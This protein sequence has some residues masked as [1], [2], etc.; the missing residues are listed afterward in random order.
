M[1]LMTG[2]LFISLGIIALNVF[3]KVL[4][5]QL[6]KMFI[7]RKDDPDFITSTLPL[8]N[9]YYMFNVTNP[10]E[11]LNGA[12]LRVNEVGPFIFSE[13][14]DKRD[15]EWNDTE[16]S[17]KYDEYAVF[18]EEDN[19]NQTFSLDEMVTTFNPVVLTLAAMIADPKFPEYLYIPFQIL[20]LRFDLRVFITRP[21]RELL[22]GGFESD[23]IKEMYKIT[24][25]ESF[26]Q[27]KA[28]FLFAAN[29]SKTYRF[30]EYTGADD[31]EK[32]HKIIEI[33]DQTKT[34]LWNDERCDRIEGF[35]GPPFPKPITKNTTLYM[36]SEGM[37][38][39]ITFD[40]DKEV[41]LKK[42]EMFR[43]KV[44][45]SLLEAS[46]E[47]EC[48]CN[49]EFLCRNQFADFSSI[50]EGIPL[51]ASYPHFYLADQKDIDEI[52]GLN[53]QEDIHETYMDIEP[54]TGL[55]LRIRKRVQVNMVVRR[56]AKLP[57]FSK[58][59]EGI[60]PIFW[61]NTKLDAPG[62]KLDK[63]YYAVII[64]SKVMIGSGA[65]FIVIGVISIAVVAA[66]V[67]GEKQ[68]SM[69][70][71]FTNEIHSILYQST[72]PSIIERNNNDKYEFKKLAK[73]PP[74]EKHVIL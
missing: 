6:N 38:R 46:K 25:M 41:R 17:V 31:I 37:R 20:I 74:S 4:Q 40:Y 3:P 53:P 61:M 33:D 11:F 52:S 28:G 71:K 50:S 72:N 34:D 23:L 63:L 66:L 49:D 67:I 57:I 55:L 15:V 58:V 24:K 21:V 13:W 45:D 68:S 32:L 47:N 51:V 1:L 19:R 69:I 10:S 30:K 26:S 8:Y 35:T 2:L 5:K 62:D 64:S 73:S 36:Y 70:R 12:Q 43:F 39:S 42:L 18:H 7:P 9:E 16:H 22:F 56:Y 44:P 29:N 48:F 60:V 54:K 59:R 14:K 65:A 27:G